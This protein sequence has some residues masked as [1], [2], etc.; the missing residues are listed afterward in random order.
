MFARRP[1]ARI[2]A[3]SSRLAQFQEAFRIQLAGVL[4]VIEQR[5][6]LRRFED[7]EKNILYE[8]VI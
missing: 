1:L 8:R 2:L 7:A 3:V 5:P 4:R 6:S